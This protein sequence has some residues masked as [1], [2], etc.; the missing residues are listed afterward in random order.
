MNEYKDKFIKLNKL[1]IINIDAHKLRGKNLF[2][3]I[4]NYRKKI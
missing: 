4:F 1:K 2:K 3:N